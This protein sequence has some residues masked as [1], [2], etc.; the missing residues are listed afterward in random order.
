MDQVR[1][2]LGEPHRVSALGLITWY[3]PGDGSLIYDPESKKLGGWTEPK[4]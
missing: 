3:Y 2:L 1:D 4:R